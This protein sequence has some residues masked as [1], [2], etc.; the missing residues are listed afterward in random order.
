[1]GDPAMMSGGPAT[2]ESES[3]PETTRDSWAGSTVQETW[4]S[5]REA[6][7]QEVARRQAILRACREFVARAGRGKKTDATYQFVAAWNATHPPAERIS[8]ATLYRWDRLERERGRVGLLPAYATGPR[9]QNIPPEVRELFD[10][11]YL[12]QRRLTVPVTRE[13]VKGQLIIEGSPL[14]EQ[15]ASV[16]TFRRYARRIP[17]PARIL[18]REGAD[19]FRQRCEPTMERDYNQIPVMGCW[20][21]DHYTFKQF[22]LGEDGRPIRPVKTEWLDMRSRR[23]VGWCI[24]ANPSQETALA[25]LAMGIARFG[26][27]PEV[28]TDN[29][30]EFST[31]TMAG[32]SRRSRV[33]LDEARIRALTEHLGIVWHFSIPKR[34]EGRGMIERA[35]GVDLDR[36]DRLGPGFTGRGPEGKPEELKDI[37]KKPELLKTIQEFR[38][39]YARYAESVANE[40]PHEGDGMDGRSPREVFE[41]EPYVK[42]TATQ[43]ELRLLFM[44]ASRPVTI[45]ARGIHAFDG[46]YWSEAIA[47]RLGQK[48]YY[49]NEPTDLSILH[50]FTYPEDQ[51]ICTLR[52]RDRAGATSQMHKQI[53]HDR[54]AARR[55]AKLWINHEKQAARVPDPLAAMAASARANAEARAVS[56][57]GAGPGGGEKTPKPAGRV[58]E[59]VRTPFRGVIE[60]AEAEERR[61]VARARITEE[62][63]LK[64]RPLGVRPASQRPSRSDLSDEAIEMLGRRRATGD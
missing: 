3:R 45:Q 2:R 26:I 63:D 1:V 15:L 32:K 56:P 28:Y 36:F 20:V 46:W 52:R 48:V 42:R 64:A 23:R 37:L 10:G 14:A 7:R 47:P 9:E 39:E 61:H 59:I 16:A 17:L 29:G 49:R 21:G 22:V 8:A 40:M 38:A 13:V 33:R 55:A 24:E 53:L 44:R 51:Y 27:P 62:E 58:V 11:L 19:A 50:V 57:E 43:A 4:E 30:R 31:T 35:F 34:P 5:A 18:A 12:N 41:A 25:A 54:K 60:A 6:D